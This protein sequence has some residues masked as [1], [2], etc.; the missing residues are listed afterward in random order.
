MPKKT[1]KEK[2]LAN[3]RKRLKII[4][5]QIKKENIEPKI[6]KKETTIEKSSLI[7][8]KEY[9]SLKIEEKKSINYNFFLD[10]KKSL[11]LSFFLIVFEFFLYLT[12]L[13]K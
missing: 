13:I 1:K 6:E 2:I 12:K 11:F 9:Q 10:L 8:P 7:V 5:Q 3:Y 4:Q